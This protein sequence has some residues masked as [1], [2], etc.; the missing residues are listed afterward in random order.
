MTYPHSGLTFHRC[1][2]LNILSWSSLPHRC[3]SV[4]FSTEG[5]GL[6]F[7]EAVLLGEAPDLEVQFCSGNRDVF[8]FKHV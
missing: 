6:T 5:W 2:Y 4:T 8:I 1:S 3:D 7:R